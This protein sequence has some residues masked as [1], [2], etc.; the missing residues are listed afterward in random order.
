MVHACNP[1]TREAEAGGSQVQG[2][3]RLHS[4]T[5][6]LSHTQKMIRKSAITYL[7]WF[8]TFGVKSREAK[9]SQML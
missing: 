4:K 8:K 7:T 5:L 6:F 1:S 9:W 2:Q 3:P